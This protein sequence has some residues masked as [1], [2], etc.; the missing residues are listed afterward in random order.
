MDIL[1]DGDSLRAGLEGQHVGMALSEVIQ[2]SL[3]V[4]HQDVPISQLVCLSW[5]IAGVVQLDWYL[6][7]E[8]SLQLAGLS[9]ISLYFFNFFFK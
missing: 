4:K 8:H 1:L 3:V 9:Q 5:K 6:E 2:I 7:T